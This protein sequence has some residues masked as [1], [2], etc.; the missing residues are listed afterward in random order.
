MKQKIAVIS[1]G[2]SAEHDV[3]IESGK[4]VLENINK[5]K[6]TPI[7]IVIPKKDPDWSTIIAQIQEVDCVFIALHGPF[8]ED[9]TFQGLC[10]LL[11]VPY[12]GPGVLASSLGMDKI[13]FRYLM[14]NAEIPIPNWI[15]IRSIEEIDSISKKLGKPP[16]F[17]KPSDQGSSVGCSIV[18]R[19]KDLNNALTEAFS[20]SD[21]V[22]IDEYIQGIELTAAILGNDSLKALPIVEIKPNFGEFF[23]YAS[24]Y[25]DG[26]ADEICPARISDELANRVQKIALDVYQLLGAKGFSRVDFIMQEEKLYVLEINTIP[27][28]TPA[29]LFPKAAVAEGISYSELIDLLISYAIEK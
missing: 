2:M 16:Y 6:Y 14:E 20:Y 26:G 7:S 3:S 23:D 4:Q 11:K 28:L 8:G 9:G 27:G 19:D 5:K 10:E 1:G 29:S 21:E 24:K 17:V 22:I 15:S 25:D 18:K 13:R 12:T